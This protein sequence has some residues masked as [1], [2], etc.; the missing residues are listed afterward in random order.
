MES[1]MQKMFN[2]FFGDRSITPRER[3]Y[4]PLVDLREEDNQFVLEVD[5]P[6]FKKD[7][8]NIEVTNESVE[9]SAEHSEEKEEQDA[10]HNYLHRE[11][12]AYKFYRNVALPS[13]INVDKISSAF[14]DGTLKLEMGK[15]E[16]TGKK[17]LQIS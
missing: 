7:E 6:G 3:V 8:I 13:P 2:D 1:D 12:C 10:N 5:L 15:M 11:R 14:N 9:I 17:R 16:G 4:A